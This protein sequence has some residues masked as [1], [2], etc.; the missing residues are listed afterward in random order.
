MKLIVVHE[1]ESED[2]MKENSV[3]ESFYWSSIKMFTYLSIKRGIANSLNYY[4]FS[5]TLVSDQKLSKVSKPI[6]IKCIDQS[7][8]VNIRTFWLFLGDL[9][10]VCVRI[11]LIFF[12]T[13]KP[14]PFL[15]LLQSI[16]TKLF[17]IAWLPNCR[18]VNCKIWNS[19]FMF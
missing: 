15:F 16:Q 3:Y 9:Q 7:S 12:N 4:Y 1:I 14:H 11:V 18:I 19:Q 6:L 17:L 13:F 8:I 10:E 5:T 2:K